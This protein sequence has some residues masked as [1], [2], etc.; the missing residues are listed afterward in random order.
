MT[1]HPPAVLRLVYCTYIHFLCNIC[2]PFFFCNI[3]LSP[4]PPFIAGVSA[5]S[6][7]ERARGSK[8]SAGGCRNRAVGWRRWEGGKGEAEAPH[9]TGSRGPTMHPSAVAGTASSETAQPAELPG[10][11]DR[12]APLSG[13][14]AAPAAVQRSR[15]LPNFARGCGMSK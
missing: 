14:R 10:R 11:A 13:E 12:P 6:E 4:P 15:R 8:E 2:T 1:V 5:V 3:W 7:D 9:N